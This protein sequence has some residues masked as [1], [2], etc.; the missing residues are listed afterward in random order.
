MYRFYCRLINKMRS[1]GWAIPDSLFI[2]AYYYLNVGERLNVKNPQTFTEKMQWL[3]LH[4]H[5]ELYHSL[6]DKL[7]VKDYVAKA[8]GDEYVIKTL[9]VWDSVDEIDISNLPNQFVLKTTNGGGST[10]VVICKDKKTFDLEEAKRKL[11]WSASYDIYQQMGEWVYK[12]VKPRIIAEELLVQETHKDYLRDYKWYCFDGDPKFCQVIQ[13]RESKETIDFFDSEWRH[14][15]FVGLNPAAGPAA[16][17]PSRP[18]NL[19]IQIKIAKELS[20]NIPF[21]RI[22]LYS[23]N[24]KTYFGEITFYPASGIGSFTPKKYN[25]VLGEL[26]VLPCKTL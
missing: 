21:S 13:D 19:E 17:A 10:G 9:A 11:R 7:T 6:V 24:K 16:V 4:D 18:D 26:L 23:I 25:N 5:K 1:L 15:E 2:P 14:Q 8:I 20:R 22:D 3:K 12:G